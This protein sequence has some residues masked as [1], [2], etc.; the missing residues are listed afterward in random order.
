MRS[1]WAKATVRS[2]RHSSTSTSS[3]PRCARSTAASSRSAAKP[4][5]V[6]I[7]IVLSALVIFCTSPQAPF[8][9]V[10]LDPFS[11]VGLGEAVGSI[12]LESGRFGE[13]EVLDRRRCLLERTDLGHELCGLQ[14]FLR[15]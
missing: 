15:L 11:A 8:A 9:L 12:A 2:P 5:P 3:S 6:P 4:A 10:G 13:E 7:R 1:R 14:H